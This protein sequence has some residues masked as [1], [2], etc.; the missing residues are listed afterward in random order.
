[1]TG[2]ADMVGIVVNRDAAFIL[3]SM[4]LMADGRNRIS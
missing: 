4:A 3:T 1:M 2:G